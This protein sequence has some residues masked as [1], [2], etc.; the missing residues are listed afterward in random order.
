MT[1]WMTIEQL[2]KYLNV[3]VK[4]LYRMASKGNIP[5]YR[6]GKRLIRFRRNEVE[7]WL[8]QNKQGSKDVGKPPEREDDQ[9]GDS[10]VE[11][12]A[13]KLATEI[14]LSTKNRRRKNGLKKGG[15]KE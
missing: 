15:G 5:S 11:R 13:E 14:I 3:S 2:G 10:S 12:T 6:L 1:E 7:A 9:D 4:M 8:I